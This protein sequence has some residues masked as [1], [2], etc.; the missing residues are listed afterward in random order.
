MKLIEDYL[1]KMADILVSLSILLY[2][3]NI[4]WMELVCWN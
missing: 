2:I 3:L 4:F 1:N